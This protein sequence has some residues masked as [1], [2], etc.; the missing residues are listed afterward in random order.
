MVGY[1]KESKA[2]RL[3]DPIKHEVING[4]YVIFNGKIYGATLLTSTSILSYD[5]VEVLQIL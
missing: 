3:F 5:S 2:Y 1:S 4:K